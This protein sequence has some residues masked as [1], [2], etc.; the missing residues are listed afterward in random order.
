MQHGG[1]VDPGNM[2]VYDTWAVVDI[3]M[4]FVF[5]CMYVQYVCVCV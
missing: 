5:V 3:S 2:E 1:K 4:L